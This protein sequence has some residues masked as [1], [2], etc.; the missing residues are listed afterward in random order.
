M[1][2]SSAAAPVSFEHVPLQTPVGRRVALVASPT[3]DLVVTRE[4]LAELRRP[5][6]RPSPVDDAIVAA[7]RAAREMG[8]FVWRSRGERAGSWT[9]AAEFSTDELSEVGYHMARSHI[10]LYRRLVAAGCL[11]ILHVDLGF[12][13]AEAMKE[14]SARL[15]DEIERGGSSGSTS[16][17]QAGSVRQL[18]LWMLRHLTMFLAS[19]FE[20]VMGGT[21]PSMWSVVDRRAAATRSLVE[22]L[23]PGV[24]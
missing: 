17:F 10:P 24:V 2:L 19:S 20:T 3:A 4:R 13:E 21:L 8:L 22:A 18:D 12:R 6:Q 11:L 1:S 5:V 23:P 14:G 15:R 7:G 9:F 16:R